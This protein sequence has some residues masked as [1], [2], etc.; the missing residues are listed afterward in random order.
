VNAEAQHFFW[1]TLHDDSYKL[2]SFLLDTVSDSHSLL[3]GAERK[4]GL[5]N[6][7][8]FSLYKLILDIV[9]SMILDEVK[10]SN[11]NSIAFRHELV[12]LVI[13]FNVSAVV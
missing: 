2:F 3:G 12:G 9:V 4:L 8:S 13:N 1:S 5:E 6:T 7:L 11:V 10:E